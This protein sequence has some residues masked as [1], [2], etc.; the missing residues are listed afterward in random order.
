MV[1]NDNQKSENSHFEVCKKNW[2][3]KNE[4]KIG[5]P[6]TY[7]I[8]AS[9]KARE[10]FKKSKLICVKKSTRLAQ[11]GYCNFNHLKLTC[12]IVKTYPWYN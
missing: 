3:G 5:T 11:Y 6:S 4:K 12:K 8:S 2:W 1:R 10:F 7:I 9:G